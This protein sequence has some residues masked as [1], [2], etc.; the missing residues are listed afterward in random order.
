MATTRRQPDPVF[1]YLKKRQAEMIATLRGLVQLESPSHHKL[2]LDRLGEHL[3]SEFERRGGRWQFHRR[4]ENGNHLQVDFGAGGK[5]ILLL[6]HFDTVYELGTLGSMPFRIADGRAWGPGAFDMKGGIVLMLYAL[7]ALKATLSLRRPVTVLLVT[8]EE[9]GSDSSRSLTESLAKR[10]AA[11]LVLEPAAG[12]EGAVKTARKGVGTF[13]LKVTGKAAHAGLDFQAGA[14]AIEELAQQIGRISGFTDLK[15]G[16]TVSTG[17]VR[18]GTRTN[19]VPAEAEAEIDARI[20]RVADGKL[21][22]KKMRSLKPVNRRCRLEVSGGVNRPP[23]ERSRQVAALY[24]L[25]KRLAAPLG[26]DLKE[27]AVGGGSDGNFTAA[28]GVPT[29]D[30]LGAVGNGAHSP[31]EHV[32]IEELPRR[33]ALL[34][35]LVQNL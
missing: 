34:A 17:I 32:V 2:S 9:I 20:A 33:A 8:D 12:P 23:L 31:Q 1:E 18:G 14:N 35:R 29:L 10:S 22:E 5:P 27:A 24:E 15:R 4:P 19:V 11:V 28:L 30:G 13:K 7:E 6:G 21:I 3:A 16:I 25:A 26:I